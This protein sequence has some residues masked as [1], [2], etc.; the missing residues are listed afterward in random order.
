MGVLLDI[1]VF[2]I[3]PLEKVQLVQAQDAELPQAGVEHHAFIQQQLPADD[4]VASFSIAE[5][6]DAVHEKLL[7]GLEVKGD[8]D[9][10]GLV[11]N[12][13][14][15]DDGGVDEAEL[16]IE[17]AVVLQGFAD[18]GDIEDVTL[19]ERESV[20][21]KLRSEKEIFFFPG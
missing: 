7:V 4:L 20:F 1:G 21:Q 12:I 9:D 14:L 10:A 15:G 17:F 16:A 19:F 3:E 8:I 11:V 2:R 5:E 6:L 13:G 18:Q